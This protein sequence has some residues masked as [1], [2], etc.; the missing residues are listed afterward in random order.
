MFNFI[1][2]N[3]INNRDI[4]IFFVY[5]KIDSQISSLA[6]IQFGAQTLINLYDCVVSNYININLLNDTDIEIIFELHKIDSQLSPLAFD[7]FNGRL[8]SV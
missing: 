2:I 7:M 4:E 1:N 8:Y 3:L 6:C 5:Q